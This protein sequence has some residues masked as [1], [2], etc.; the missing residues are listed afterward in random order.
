MAALHVHRALVAFDVD[1]EPALARDVGRE[2][3]RKAVGVV[4]LENGVAVDDLGDAQFRDRS[5]ENLHAGLERARELLAFLPQHIPHERLLRDELGIRAAHHLRERRHEI[6]KKCRAAAEL[7]AVAHRT[8]R[9][10]AQ[11][12]AAALVRRNHAVDDEEAAGA[13]VIRDHS[14]RGILVVGGA[15]QTRGLVNEVDEEVDVV[16][17]GDALHHRRH[18]LEARAG[19][20]RRLRQRRELA[21]G[22]AVELH[23]HEIPDLDP[24]VAVRIGRARRPSRNAR[25]VVIED[26][27][28]GTTRARIA[29][30]PEIVGATLRL[31]ADA[32]DLLGRQA[33]HLV[34]KVVRLVIGLV[35]RHHEARGI[36]LQRARQ[37]VPA[38]A[39]RILLEV[40]AE[41]EVAEHLEE[42]VV[43]RR[44]T[45]VL[46][47]VV[48]TARAHAALA[49]RRAHIVALVLA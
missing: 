18:A 12:V 5:V 33:D 38:E 27:G 37:E 32:H 3:G 34:P 40:V 17:V 28:A 31:V 6:V 30:L 21:V 36:D 11:N 46:E 39:D 24:T 35:D 20:H 49:A 9:D 29:H 48:L 15:E 43:A 16:V 26:F 41:G 13:D 25:A 8:P 2:V 23:E 4:K 19:I 42:G 45:D 47:V 7:V 44:V 10:A 14:Q 1:A 22:R